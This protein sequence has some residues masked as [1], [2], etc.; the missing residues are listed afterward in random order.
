MEDILDVLALAFYEGLKAN[1]EQKDNVF[2][3]T[4]SDGQKFKV[5]VDKV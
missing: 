2:Y 1:I 3:I 5:E 4:F